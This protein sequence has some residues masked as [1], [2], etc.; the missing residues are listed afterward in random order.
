MNGQPINLETLRLICKDGIYYNPA[1][2]HYDILQVIICDGCN[3]E[4]LDI[5][6]GF[7]DYDLCFDCVKIITSNDRRNIPM[8]TPSSIIQP[9]NN[10]YPTG[11]PISQFLTAQPLGQYPSP[12]PFGQYP[13][14]Y[15]FDNQHTYNNNIPPP[16][17]PRIYG[18]SSQSINQFEQQPLSST[19]NSYGSLP[20]C[21]T[22]QQNQKPLIGQ[23]GEPI[24]VINSVGQ[25]SSSSSIN[26]Q[27]PPYTVS[28]SFK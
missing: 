23:F 27:P 2:K 22:N 21:T 7:E 18:Q 3:K 12:A 14:P 10:I 24:T 11:S 4:H 25:Y 20:L 19:N 1:S 28:S 17:Y 6:I 8:I 16:Y 15:P 13:P 26:Q 5:C 9:F